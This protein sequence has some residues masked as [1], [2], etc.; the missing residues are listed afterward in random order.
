MKNEKQTDSQD[1][2]G[3]S[4]AQQKLRKQRL[5]IEAEEEYGL[6]CDCS[7]PVLNE[8]LVKRTKNKLQ[9]YRCGQCLSLWVN[10]SVVKP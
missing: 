8:D 6:E 4:E 3:S 9:H 7:E 10:P 5:A 2:Q 1:Q